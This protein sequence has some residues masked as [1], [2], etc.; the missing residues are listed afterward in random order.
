M[1]GFS[2]EESNLIS[3]F[4][5]ESR[6]EVIEDISSALKYL[7]DNSHSN[8]DK[9]IL[10]NRTIRHITQTS[11][12]KNGIRT[13]KNQYFSPQNILIPLFLPVPEPSAY[14]GEDAE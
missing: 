11:H 2:V 8:E 7:E 14:I 3:I 1:N 10:T 6:T 12:I 5:G 13:W 4:A 9:K